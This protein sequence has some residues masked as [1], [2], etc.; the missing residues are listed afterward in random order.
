M[1]LA[2][3]FHFL[4]AQHVSDINISIIRSLR[5]FLLNG[6][7]V[8]SLAPML[9]H[10]D[11]HSPPCILYFYALG[12]QVHINTEVTRNMRRILRGNITK[13]YLTKIGL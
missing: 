13:L 3:L 2:I 1:S 6:I 5:L 7:R 4:Y 9:K 8:C 11:R 12:N 10:G